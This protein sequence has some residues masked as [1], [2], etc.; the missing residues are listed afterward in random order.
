MTWQERL[1]KEATDIVN[2]GDGKLELFANPLGKD[3]TLVKIEAGKA[4][5]FQIDK[6]LDD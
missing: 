4:F 5:R 2:N 1:V 6:V 3:K